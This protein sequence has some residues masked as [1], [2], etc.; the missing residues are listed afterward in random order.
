MEHNQTHKKN[1][2]RNRKNNS[3]C[4]SCP[5]SPRVAMGPSDGLLSQGPRKA[6]AENFTD[7]SSPDSD[8]KLDGSKSA[9]AVPDDEP[10]S[11]KGR[12][13]RLQQEEEEKKKCEAAKSKDKVLS[14]LQPE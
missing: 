8:F 6:A 5:L 13:E 10:E 7:S 2:T 4:V 9:A 12:K 11:D 3:Y 14:S 1:K